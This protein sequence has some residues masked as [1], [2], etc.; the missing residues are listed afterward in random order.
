MWANA[1]TLHIL[2]PGFSNK[3]YKNWFVVCGYLLTTFIKLIS[4]YLTHRKCFAARFV[5]FLLYFLTKNVFFIE[6]PSLFDKIGKLRCSYNYIDECETLILFKIKLA[7]FFCPNI[8][9]LCNILG[10]I[11]LIYKSLYFNN[12][13]KS[14]IVTNLMLN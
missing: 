10:H 8:E 9:V 3:R 11:I 13:W 12:I 14:L 5:S 2:I 4:L 7:Q 6:Y 1:L